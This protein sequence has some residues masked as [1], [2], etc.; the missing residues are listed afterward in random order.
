MTLTSMPRMRKDVAH[1]RDAVAGA[2]RMGSGDRHQAARFDDAE[3]TAIVDVVGAI[4]GRPAL[5]G[6][7]AVQRLNLVAT[8]AED[9]RSASG[10]V[11]G[12]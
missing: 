9:R 10:A 4:G 11:R 8:Q 6:I 12:R 1:H 3:V 7:E 2:D 5:A